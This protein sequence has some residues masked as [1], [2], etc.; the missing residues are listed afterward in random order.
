MIFFLYQDTVCQ[1]TK[2]SLEPQ[3][4]NTHAVTSFT[5]I[6]SHSIFEQLLVSK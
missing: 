5:I 4:E 6:N 3:A 2:Q 1:I